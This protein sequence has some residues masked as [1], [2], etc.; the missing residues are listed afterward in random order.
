MT[1]MNCEHSGKVKLTKKQAQQE[2]EIMESYGKKFGLYV[3]EHCKTYHISRVRF[4]ID[5]VEN[6]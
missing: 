3:C 4:K 5:G 1:I 2:I 6:I